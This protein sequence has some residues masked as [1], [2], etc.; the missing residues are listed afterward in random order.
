M[1]TKQ[2]N[3][4]LINQKFKNYA[5]ITNGKD[6]HVDQRE[7]VKWNHLKTVEKE[8][9][10][11]KKYTA[12]AVTRDDVIQLITTLRTEIESQVDDKPSKSSVKQVIA[13]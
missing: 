7:Y 5:P 6:A 3:I 10:T 9:D 13:L 11:L 12:Q 4:D 8:L 2:S 1:R